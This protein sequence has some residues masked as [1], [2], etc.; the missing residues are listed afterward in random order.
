MSLL[1]KRDYSTFN[2]SQATTIEDFSQSQG[3]M[4]VQYGRKGGYM[5]ARRRM[6]RMRRRSNVPR[7]I[8]TRGTPNG[9]YEI[10]VQTLVKIYTNTSTGMY[11]TNQDTGAFS[12]L[13]G[14]RGIGIASSLDSLY[15]NLGEGT[16]PVGMTIAW[17]GFAE[18]QNVFD[19]CKI[20][21]MSFDF[22]VANQVSVAQAGNA[23]IAAPDLFLAYDPTDA[24]PPANQNVVMQYSK[25]K[26]VC[27]DTSQR[28]S[29]KI[30]PK[31][32]YDVA[33]GIDG[34]ATTTTLAGSQN[35]TYLRMD[36]P[37]AAHYGIRGWLNIPTAA[38]T[39]PVY[40]LNILVRQVRRYKVN[41]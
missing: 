19:E 2:F 22:W 41:K 5:V 4:P 17:P 6:R 38:S 21:D 13:T 7:A 30:Y 34:T 11:V 28:T 15:I 26:R 33:T 32:R 12:G 3:N 27:F 39:A 40:E 8:A 1:G 36:S 31:M 35:S 10:P 25:L 37:A 18:L 9:Y 14:Y 16:T 20:V 29:W 24:Q 23:V